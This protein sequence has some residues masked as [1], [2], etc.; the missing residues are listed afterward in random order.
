VEGGGEVKGRLGLVRKTMEQGGGAH[1]HAIVGPKRHKTVSNLMIAIFQRDALST[2]GTQ[3]VDALLSFRSRPLVAVEGQQ[4]NKGVV[5]VKSS[6]AIGVIAVSV[7]LNSGMKN[8]HHVGQACALNQRMKFL[9][10]H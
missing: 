1:P 5:T 4:D 3:R 9:F 8:S 2:V 10:S 6:P 7:N